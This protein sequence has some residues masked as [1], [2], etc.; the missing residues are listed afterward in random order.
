MTMFDLYSFSYPGGVFLDDALDMWA[1]STNELLDKQLPPVPVDEDVDG[2]LARAAQAE[3]QVNVNIHE[4]SSQQPYRD[5]VD[6][7]TGEQTYLARSLYRFLPGI[8]ESGVAVYAI[9][10]WFDGW[11]RDH[12]VWFDNLTVPKRV[13][14]TPFDHVMGTDP[15]WQAMSGA[16][17]DGD[18][19]IGQIAT[20]LDAEYLRF[21]DHHLKG[22][23]NGIMHEP[24]VW[25]YTLGAPADQAWSSSE[26]WPLANQE[27]TRYYFGA[28]PSGSVASL[29]DGSLDTTTPSADVGQDDFVVDYATTMGPKTRW[30]RVVGGEF[31]YGDMAERGTASLTYTTPPLADPLEITGHPIV[32]PWVS[33]SADDG[34]LF[35]YLEK[36]QADG[37]VHYL[38]EGVLRASHRALADPPYRYIGLPYHRSFAED[39]EPLPADTPVELVFD[40]HPTSVLFQSGER[41]RVRVVGADA[42]TFLTPELDPAP[43]VSVHRDAA[44]ASYI[45]LPV[46]PGDDG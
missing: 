22:I 15:G 42:D 43:T 38:T 19:Q 26:E 4:Q 31:E 2:S 3:H 40:L 37:Y 13:L 33:S 14:F 16:L 24:P 35:V 23:D 21:F 9:A 8:N 45:E 36:V 44:H 25:Y 27:P 11:P 18:F 6:G 41:L 10:G 20:F 46:I 34:D 1:N 5:A 30:Q 28:G 17:L 7:Q 12:A 39:V 29:N 32:H